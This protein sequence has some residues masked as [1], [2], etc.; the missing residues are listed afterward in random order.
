MMRHAAVE[1]ATPAQPH[2]RKPRKRR[3]P[4]RTAARLRLLRQRARGWKRQARRAATMALIGAMTAQAPM[5]AY[6]Q[7]GQ[8]PMGQPQGLVNGAASRGLARLSEINGSG[9][10]FM[11]YG[12]N[13]A[14]RGL[15]YIGSYMT[16]GGFIPYAQDDL[17]GFWSADLR[18]HLSVNGG[19]FSNVGVVRKQLLGSGSLLGVGVYWDYD[20]D[21]YQYAG[22]GNSS[23][24]QFGHVY[25]QVGVSGEILT[26]WGDIRSNGYM[27][28]GTT[29]YTVAAPG[30]PFYQN[31]IFCQYGLDAAL[32]GADLEVGAY[33][34]ALADFAGMISVGGY[35]L[36]NT[37]NKWQTGSNQGLAIVPWFG[38]VYTRIDMTFANNWDFSLQ[39]NNDSYFDS[40][41]FARLTYRLGGSRRRNVPDQL[42]QPMM[43]NE[44]IVRAHETPEIARNLANSNNPWRVIHVNNAAP[45][46]GTG[47]Y[48]SPFTTLQ[49]AQTQATQQWD[50]IYVNEGL[51]TTIPIYYGGSFAFQNADQSL[52]GSGGDF[53]IQVQQGCGIRTANND[54]L[55]TIAAQTTNNPVLNNPAGPS[56][57]TNNKGGLTIANLTV[58]GSQTGLLASSNLTGAPKA[59]GTT[60][61]PQGTTTAGATAV[62]NVTISGDG[63]TNPQRGVWLTDA[64]GDIEFTDTVIGNMNNT[65]FRVDRGNANIDFSG[66]LT[67]DVAFNGNVPSTIIDINNTTGGTINL[68][69]GGAPSGSVIPNE[70]L[71]IG[72]EGIL[73]ES[74]TG[75]VINIGSTTLLNN[76]STAIS[77]QTDAS[78][79]RIETVAN[80]QANPL[81]IAGIVKDTVGA[82]I[83]ISGGE[84]DFTY[85][86]TIRN[87]PTIGATPSYIIQADN[88]SGG[89]LNIG[90]PGVYPLHDQGDGVLLSSFSAGTTNITGLDLQG[91]GTTGILVENSTADFNFFTTRIGQTGVLGGGPTNQGILISGNVGSTTQFRNLDISLGGANAEGLRA[92]NGGS[93]NVFGASTLSNAS[94][95]EAAIY[96]DGSTALGTAPTEGMNW[97]SISS[98]NTTQTAGTPANTTPPFDTGVTTA[99]MIG[100]FNAGGSGEINVT[101]SFTVGGTAADGL[102][103][104][105]NGS[106]DVNVSGTTINPLP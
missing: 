67:N 74:N 28:V 9:P 18:G 52:V 3:V 55:F 44:H 68:A 69:Y 76:A 1:T 103:V 71:D 91:T 106:I 58:T 99:I 104:N 47:T 64:T 14:D 19:F 26:D 100:E 59:A 96:I 40:T 53:T 105:S 11:Y 25:N 7:F 86:G 98:G 95:T 50:I 61:N 101:G 102:N 88:V 2:H 15:G 78:T 97:T 6:A 5:S 92:V 27:P 42:E 17:G 72:G 34:P 23:F 54:Y 57:E 94:T 4:R 21:L 63:S 45:A 73:I 13:G 36:G 20:G 24:G 51:S 89:A 66:T 56:I 35:A 93:L 85:Y 16:L 65:G 82:A 39:Y 84:P 41:G 83:A 79:T 49:E 10:G 46:G 43:R 37:F 33:I 75:T 29:A 32:G 80:T 90:G 12:I 8:A 60:A 22:E 48:E 70:I 81:A 30:M 87:T 31:N 77:I 62:R 38:G